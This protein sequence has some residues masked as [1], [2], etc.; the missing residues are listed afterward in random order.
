MHR[1]HLWLSRFNLFTQTK[2]NW[3][4]KCSEKQHSGVRNKNFSSSNSWQSVE[5]VPESEDDMMGAKSMSSKKKKKVENDRAKYIGSITCLKLDNSEHF[6]RYQR[7]FWAAYVHMLF[8]TM[9]I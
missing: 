6:M 2:E 9:S 4:K 5:R 3:K 8:F 1:F 7:N